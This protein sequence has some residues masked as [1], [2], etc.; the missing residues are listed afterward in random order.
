MQEVLTAEDAR[1]ETLRGRAAR[2]ILE[3]LTQ[4]IIIGLILANA[5]TLGLETSASIMELFG[6][7]LVALDQ[8]FLWIF[9]AEIALRIYA[10]RGR[11]FRDPWG[12]FDIIVVAIAWL[13]ASG[14]LSVLRALRIL[15][16]LRLV[17]VVPS[18]RAATSILAPWICLPLM[19]RKSPTRSSST[20]SSPRNAIFA[21][22]AN[23]ASVIGP[24]PISPRQMS[25]VAFRPPP[26]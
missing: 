1:D 8:A 2:F 24:W 26:S 19:L 6:G 21:S 12:V 13:P 7:V 10:F 22:A 20:L 25:S 18:L 11:F 14:E 4:R 17:T 9:T 15:R 5:V 3:P 16:V 23:S